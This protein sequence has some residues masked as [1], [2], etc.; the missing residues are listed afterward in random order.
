VFTFA[1]N[2]LWGI[3]FPMASPFSTANLLIDHYLPLIKIRQTFLLTLAGVAG[4]LCQPT[5]PIDWL[6]FTGLVG[7]LI[8]T[9]SGCTVLNMLFDRDI[10]G[11]MARTNQRPMPLGQVK[12]P[13]V[14]Y[15]GIVLITMGLLW[16]YMISILYFMIGLV[17]VS[18]NV[19][20]YTLWLKRRSAWSI[21][22][23][24]LAGGMPIMAGRAL[25]IGHIDALGILLA[26][27]IVCW[28]PSHNLT[29]SML[30][31]IDYKNAGIPTF[32]NVFGETTTRIT[33]AFSSM[34]VASL[35]VVISSRI[36]LP[37]LIFTMIVAGS[38]GLVGLTLFGW[39][40]PSQ[41]KTEI[42]YKYSSLYMLVS[43]LLL[44]FSGLI[45]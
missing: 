24:G 23:G 40:N 3:I 30:Y 14:T 4:Y 33:L 13:F 41:K 26:L 15:L 21:L 8:V 32:L 29:L 18:L 31:S 6:H 37:T 10:D 2:N 9:I 35:M 20:V 38:I 22:W 11:K 27:V 45:K 12:V 19:L 34:L 25:A 5:S 39:A 42:L 16:A 7:S 28:I 36:V 43:M 17:G 1:N 44:A